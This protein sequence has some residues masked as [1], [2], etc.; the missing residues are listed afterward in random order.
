M[1]NLSPSPFELKKH[2]ILNE[3]RSAKKEILDLTISSPMQAGIVFDIADDLRYLAENQE[4]QF[5]APDA[6]GQLY[7]R[8]AIA[9]YAGSSCNDIFVASSTSE[10]YSALFRVFCEKGDFVLTPNPGY[11]LID[12]IA[13]L[14]GFNTHPYFLKPDF[15]GNIWEIDLDSLNSIPPNAKIFL[16]IASHN[17]TGHITTKKEF[18]H[19]LQFCENN[20]LALI[21]DAVFNAYNLKNNS[22]LSIL[23]S[24]LKPQIPILVLDGLSK[25]AGLPHIKVAWINAIV[26]EKQKQHIY[27]SLE[28]VLDSQLNCSYLSQALCARVLPRV[29][30]FQEKVIE[31]LKTNQVFWCDYFSKIGAKIIPSIGGWHQSFYF[32]NADDEELCLNLLKEKQ[33]LTYPGFLFDFEDGWLVGSIL[34]SE[35]CLQI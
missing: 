8:E 10:A 3:L 21:I 23:N 34:T 15:N 13:E 28:Y 31:K 5:C 11:P 20:N 32:P 16:L 30:G 1:K 27:N 18:E 17:P 6:C 19:I 7:A 26:P 35:N 22:Q 2:G 25:S 29:R 24:Q 9:E 12:A 33:I 14:D 4:W